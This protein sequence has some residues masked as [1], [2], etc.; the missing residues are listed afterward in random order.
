MNAWLD[1]FQPDE[2]SFSGVMVPLIVLKCPVYGM[3][4]RGEKE[5]MPQGLEW[6]LFRWPRGFWAVKKANIFF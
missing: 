4:R 1:D 2:S 6:I 3:I 5:K